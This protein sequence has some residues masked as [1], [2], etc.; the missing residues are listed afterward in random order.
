LYDE[1]DAAK[2]ITALEHF[3][4]NDIPLLCRSI[5]LELA[6]K[7]KELTNLIERP[8]RAEQCD[9]LI[10]DGKSIS[11]NLRNTREIVQ[12]AMEMALDNRTINQF[13][14]WAERE[15]PEFE[16]GNI[17]AE[18]ETL[19][20]SV[21]A[22]SRRFIEFLDVAQQKRDVV[23]SQ[24]RFLEIAGSLVLQCKPGMTRQLEA[25]LEGVI[26]PN[27]PIT[28]F[29]P[30]VL[31][32]AVDF[33]ELMDVSEEKV[34]S[35]VYDFSA[36]PSQ[37]AQRFRDFVERNREH[38]YARLEKG[39]LSFSEFLVSSEYIL[40]PGESPVDFIGI[41]TSPEMLDGD[42][43]DAPRIVVGFTGRDFTHDLIDQKIITSDP[44]IF[45]E[46]KES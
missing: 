31:P 7:A 27:V 24:H 4:F 45:L 26:Y 21:E 20:Q 18:L 34:V 23:P 6:K 9:I 5:S 12:K 1:A 35:Q 11:D 28:W 42:G 29:D 39:P 30:S 3:K 19:V 25:F 22:V 44:V 15:K 13:Q 41:Y 16:L 43:Q 37:T 33:Y 14:E 17:Q 36:R 8:T 40:H 32:G 38:I 10:A 2:I 46:L